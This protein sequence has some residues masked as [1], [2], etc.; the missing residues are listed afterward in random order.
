MIRSALAGVL[1]GFGAF[2]AGGCPVRH[3][4]VGLPGL[5][6]EGIVAS[7]GIIGGI[8]IGTQLLKRLV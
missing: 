3:M 7:I 1:I 5:A 6:M 4:F 8:Y 2:V